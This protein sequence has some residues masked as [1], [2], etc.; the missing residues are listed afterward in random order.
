MQSTLVRIAVA[1]FTF[2]LGVSAT[3]FWIASGTPGVS[4]SRIERVKHCSVNRHALPPLP[5]LPTVEALPPPP[6][7]P[8]TR[9]PISGGLLNNKTLSKPAPLYPQAAVAAEASGTVEVHVLVDEN[10]RVISA[11]AVSGHPLLREAAVDAAYG[12]RFS[13]TIFE[14]LPVKVS[15][16]ISYN[17]VLP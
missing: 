17:F 5:P 12:A 11:N 3:M 13:P 15:G 2:G 9:A 8:F 4:I 7:A 14:G 10:G 1:L 16:S 6:P